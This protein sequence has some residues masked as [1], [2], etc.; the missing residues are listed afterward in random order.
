[1]KRLALSL[2]V[3]LITLPVRAGDGEGAKQ[4]FAQKAAVS[5]IF[6]IE[7]A[8]IE[9]SQ[10]RAV[11]AKQ[12][13]QDMLRDHGRAAGLLSA[14]ARNDG[15]T[16]SQ[17]LDAQHQQKIDALKNSDPANLDQA[18]LSTQVT[19][20]QQTYELFVAYAKEGPDGPLKNAAVTML[21]DLHMHLTRVQ[22]ISNK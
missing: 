10:G 2:V 4:D 9:I 3:C 16:V 7:A 5:N 15:V 11:A 12:F 13:A 1:M 17:S 19:A 21:P 6:E 14:A 22:G 20:H 8:K 18:Y